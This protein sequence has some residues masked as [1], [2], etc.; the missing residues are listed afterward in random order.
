MQSRPHFLA[1]SFFL[2]MLLWGCAA[3]PAPAAAAP[4][5]DST[6][7]DVMLIGERHDAPGQIAQVN[8]TLLQLIREGRLA[9]LVIEMAPAGTSTAALPRDADAAAIRKALHWGD[10]SWPW[11]RY[12]P[13]ITTAVAAGVPVLGANLPQ[14]QIATAMDDVSLDAQLSEAARARLGT[15]LREGHCGLMPENRIPIMLRV[16]IARDRSMAHVLAES[17]LPGRT[18]VLLAGAGHADRALGVPQHLPTDLK[19]K[20]I[21]MVAAGDSPPGEFDAIR[22]TPAAPANNPCAALAL[23]LHDK[24]SR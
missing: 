1:V 6:P 3:P 2:S 9:A 23:N 21:A 18:A 22:A 7:P 11:N 15:A 8:D 12:A 20:S 10:K 24:T 16:Q 17:V 19:V 14:D 13:A 4:T 5:P